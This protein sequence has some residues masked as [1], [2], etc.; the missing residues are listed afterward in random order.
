[1]G[2]W[3]RVGYWFQAMA[4]HSAVVSVWGGGKAVW[5]VAALVALM[6][7]SV[8]V[9][10]SVR[11]WVALVGSVLEGWEVSV[12]LAVSKASLQVRMRSQMEQASVWEERRISCRRREE[13]P[14]QQVW[15]QEA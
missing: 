8:P 10:D 13:L 2:G 9:P 3:A 11:E 1:M 4:E 15:D 5:A 12:G 14:S 7:A 6:E